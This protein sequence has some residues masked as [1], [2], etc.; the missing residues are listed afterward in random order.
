MTKGSCGACVYFAAAAVVESSWARRGH[1]LTV[2]STQ[3]LND[4]AHNPTRGNNGCQHGGGTFV[5]TFDYIRDHGLTS[6]QN[7]PYLAKVRHFRLCRHK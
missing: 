7:Y 4:C 1:P 2:L 6:M 3:Q 5:P